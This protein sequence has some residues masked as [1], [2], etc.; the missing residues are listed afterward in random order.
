MGILRICAVKDGI[1]MG[2]TSVDKVEMLAKGFY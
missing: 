1:I 2:M